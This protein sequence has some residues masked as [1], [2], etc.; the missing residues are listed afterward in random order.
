MV[1]GVIVGVVVAVGVGMEDGTMD[2]LSWSDKVG[3]P[4]LTSGVPIVYSVSG[5]V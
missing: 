1:R 5:M 2:G 4:G 3:H